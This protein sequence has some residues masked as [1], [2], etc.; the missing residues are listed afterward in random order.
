MIEPGGELGLAQE[1]LEDDVVVAQALV[2]D[3]DDGLPAQEGLLAAIDVAEAA[4]ADALAN[5]ELA[6]RSAAQIFAVCHPPWVYHQWPDR[7]E[8]THVIGTRGCADERARA[9]VLQAL[10]CGAR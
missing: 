8:E 2:E 5:D 10:R 1:A 4:R 7:R 9:A 6:Q 3:L